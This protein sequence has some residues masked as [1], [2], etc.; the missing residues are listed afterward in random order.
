MDKTK[1]CRTFTGQR[2]F[3]IEVFGLFIYGNL[4]FEFKRWPEFCFNQPHFGGE[5]FMTLALDRKIPGTNLEKIAQYDHS[6]PGGV[7]Y[8]SAL[9]PEGM[10]VNRGGDMGFVKDVVK[11]SPSAK[12]NVYT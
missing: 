1:K 5:G 2:Y 8:P 6:R 10:N 4:D 9:V 11:Y 3:F 7:H 12:F